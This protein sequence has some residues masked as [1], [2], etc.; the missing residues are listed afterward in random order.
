MKVSVITPTADRARFL[1]GTYYLLKNQKHLN[2]EWLIY[3]TSLH[4]THFTDPRITYLFDKGIVSIGE[5][6]NRLVEKAKGDVIVHFDDDDYYAPNYLETVLKYLEKASFF[7]YHAWFSF[8]M[9]TGQFFYWDG[10]EGGEVRY[11]VN[12]LSG[13]H[14]REIQLGPY[15]QHQQE[16]L[17]YK[18]KAGYG[19]SFAY[20]KE[21]ARACSFQDIDCSEDRNFYE[22]VNA[23][24]F[25]M[26]SIA[27]KEGVVVHVIHDKNTSGEFPQYRIPRFLVQNLFPPFFSYSKFTHEN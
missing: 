6:R 16:S 12:A 14:V 2:W 19:F 27:D 17:S 4:P 1:Q 5:K 26:I 23:S 24:R 21:V 11:E 10:E 9:K 3:D 13:S 15:L 22:M 20:T 18:A 25:P 7:T 8:D